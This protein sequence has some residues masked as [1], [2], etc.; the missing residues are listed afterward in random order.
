MGRSAR[1]LEVTSYPPPRAGWGIRVEFL[2]KRLER[3]GHTCVVLNTG[4]SRRIPSPE[5]ET[6]L[7]GADFVNKVWRFARRG[8]LV[9][10]HANGDSPKGAAAG[11][12]GRADRRGLRPAPGADLPRRRDSALLSPGARAGPG[13]ALLA[14]VPAAAA[15][16]L[17][18]RGGAAADPGLRRSG[19]QDRAHSGVQ[20][21]V[22]GVHAGRAPRGAGEIPASAIRRSIF[23]YVRM[24]PLFYPVTLVKGMALL[25]RIPPRRR[26]G[27]L[28]RPEPRRGG[29]VAR[30]AER[31][32]RARAGGSDLLHRRSRSRRVPDGAA[33]I[34]ALPANADH[35]RRGLVGAGIAGAGSAGRRAATTAR[36]RRAS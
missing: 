20:P 33:A 13:P 36:G 3:E 30:R 25:A 35:R 21:R 24:R 7:G 29:P 8:F 22:P 28:R 2:K 12:A 6:V 32:R 15:D 31:H 27:D 16:H 4:A 34:R 23:T 19:R 14:A 10:A 11:A 1:I 9:H 17:Q 18:Q 5:Y 26:P